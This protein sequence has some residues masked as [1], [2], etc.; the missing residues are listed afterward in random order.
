MR[1]V[2]RHRRNQT[3]IPE[4]ASAQCPTKAQHLPRVVAAESVCTAPSSDIETA[5]P[6][7]VRRRTP[8]MMR[9]PVEPSGGVDPREGLRG[10]QLS[11]RDGGK[12][13]GAMITL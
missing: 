9:D 7:Q 12:R 3:A 8:A 10:G 5:A 2:F 13:R 11:R 4:V 6:Q 1:S